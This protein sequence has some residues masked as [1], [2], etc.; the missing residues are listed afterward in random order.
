MNVY[1]DLVHYCWRAETGW[2]ATNVTQAIGGARFSRFSTLSLI[3]ESPT[4]ASTDYHHIFGKSLNG[5]LLHY[6]RG[7]LPDGAGRT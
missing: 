1:G 4:H 2:R 6:W 5:D 7:G 3:T